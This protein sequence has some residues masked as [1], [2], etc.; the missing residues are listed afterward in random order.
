MHEIT[1]EFSPGGKKKGV[2]IV[3]QE[4]RTQLVFLRTQ[5]Q[6][7]ASLSGLRTWHCFKL[8]CR[9]QIWLGSG[10]AVELAGSYSSDLTSSL[11]TFTY[12]GCNP[13][14]NTK[15]KISPELKLV[16]LLSKFHHLIKSGDY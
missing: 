15:K 11:G 9:S 1:V 10:A 8:W 16:L 2:P 4:L 6:S 13:K 3:V 12:Q 14:K 7:L 5:A